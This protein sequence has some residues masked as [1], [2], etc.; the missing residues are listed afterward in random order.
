[1]KGSIIAIG[2]TSAPYF[3]ISVGTSEPGIQHNLLETFAVLPL[4][5]AYERIVSFP[6]G[7]TICFKTISHILQN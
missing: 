5:I 7:E 1:M 2:T 6:L 3:S 4:E